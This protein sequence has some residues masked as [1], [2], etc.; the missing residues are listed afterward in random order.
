MNTFWAV[1]NQTSTLTR[2]NYA[3]DLRIFF[4]Y[5]IRKKFRGK[6]VRD[7]TLR[8]LES[9]S[10]TEIERFISYLSNYEFHGNFESCSERAK[11]RKLSTVRALLNTFL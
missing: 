9:V 11:A 5:L 4:D 1:E 6:T 8:D 2:L 10:S 7:L 3:Y